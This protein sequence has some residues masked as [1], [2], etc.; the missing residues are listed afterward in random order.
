MTR[1]TGI[2]KQD[3]CLETVS[4]ILFKLTEVFGAAFFKKLRL[5]P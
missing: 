2:S 3:A 1:W 4:K 5:I